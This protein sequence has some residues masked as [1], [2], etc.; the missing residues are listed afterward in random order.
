MPERVV[1]DTNI[2]VSGLMWRGN[3]YRCLLLARAGVVRPVPCQPMLAELS[4]KLRDVF[5]FSEN[6]IRAVAYDL[7]TISDRVEITGEVRVVEEDPDDDM[8]VECA[9]VAGAL[10]II[11]G[12]HHL[13]NLGH[14]RGVSILSAAEF[15]ASLT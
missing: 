6:H 11:S 10:K 2:W 5:G 15:L 4:R 9:L 13:L 7:R 8:F 12:D 14:C 3:P 1:F